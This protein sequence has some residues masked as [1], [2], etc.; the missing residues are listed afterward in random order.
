MAESVADQDGRSILLDGPE[1][2]SVIWSTVQGKLI[3]YDKTMPLAVYQEDIA[4][5]VS[6]V[7]SVSTRWILRINSS[8]QNYIQHLQL[9]W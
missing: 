6:V 1:D 4:F 3:S 9:Y 7:M 2:I 5:F 8:D